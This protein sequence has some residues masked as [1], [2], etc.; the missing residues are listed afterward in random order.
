MKEIIVALILILLAYYYF[1]MT[2]YTNCIVLNPKCSD[3]KII[4]NKKYK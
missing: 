1:N 4:I 3:M 2:D